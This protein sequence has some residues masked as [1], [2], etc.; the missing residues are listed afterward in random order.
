M[1]WSPVRRGV[2]PVLV[3]L[4][5]VT[6]CGDAALL[7][8]DADQ[9]VEGIA[10]LG[11]QCP[12]QSEANPCPD[13]PY[14]ASIVILD[15]DDDPVTHV[16]AGSDGRFRVGLRPGRYTLVPVS[17]QP[18]PTASPQAVDVPAGEWPSVTVQFD[19]GIR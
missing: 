9:G 19:T 8:P 3:L 1:S 13:L 2:T 4:V 18:F 12:V 14:A 6:A 10:L 5:G 16:D 7:G 17:G 15:E 11:P